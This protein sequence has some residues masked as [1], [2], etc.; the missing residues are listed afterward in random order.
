MK[1]LIISIASVTILAIFVLLLNSGSSVATS[2]SNL[3]KSNMIHYVVGIHL[4]DNQPI[5]GDYLVVVF[6]EAG[7]PVAPPQPFVPGL[8]TYHIFEPGPVMSGTREAR[9]I[10]DSGLDNE[11]RRPFA[12]EP[13]VISGNFYNGVIYN[14]DLYPSVQGQHD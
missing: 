12:T 4:Q 1:K 8:G 14:F 6:N 10:V 7:Q 3:P 5:C 11:C 2:Q 13:D 9:F